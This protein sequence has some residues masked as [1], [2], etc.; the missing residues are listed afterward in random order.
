MSRPVFAG[1][2]GLFIALLIVGIQVGPS[3]AIIALMGTYLVYGIFVTLK[4]FLTSQAVQDALD[5]G[6]DVLHE[7][8]TEFDEDEEE[9][10]D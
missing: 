8:R 1:I 9:L 7:R 4:R 6:E 3:I 2:A 5:D 10:I